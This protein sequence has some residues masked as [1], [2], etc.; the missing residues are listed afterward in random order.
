MRVN[1][2]TYLGMLV[3]HQEEAYVYA[4]EVTLACGL[5][6]PTMRRCTFSVRCVQWASAFVR[7]LHS[8]SLERG[9]SGAAKSLINVEA[10]LQP[11]PCSG[12]IVMEH[13]ESL[14]RSVNA[15]RTRR[16]AKL[17]QCKLL[18]QQRGDE[19]LNVPDFGAR[20]CVCL[21]APPPPSPYKCVLSQGR[22]SVLN[23]FSDAFYY[24]PTESPG[25]RLPVQR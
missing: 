4:N 19:N 5:S 18:P 25:Y 10:V 7:K 6:W 9:S 1:Y 3:G 23:S 16:K 2:A 11:K 22:S 13:C 20:R 17:Y 24:Q 14:Q 8:V 15:S 21:S 12:G